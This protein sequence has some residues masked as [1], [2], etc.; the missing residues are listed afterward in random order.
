MNTPPPLPVPEP[1]E[2][3]PAETE[4]AWLA[5]RAYRDMPPEER[6]IR[7]TAAKAIST[8]SRWY[9]DHNWDER[10]KAHDAVMDKISVEERKKIYERSAREIAIDHMEILADLRD[11]AK[12][13][14][15]LFADSMRQQSMPGSIKPRDLVRFVEVGIK[16]D[17]L[18]RGETTENVGT[19]DLDVSKLSLQEVKDLE[20]LMRKAG[21]NVG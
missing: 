9:R 11:I 18:V 7:R 10:V 17:R 15:A 5:F 12:T 3:Q 21:M 4:E 20:K 13:E 16:M 14:L 2:R 8:L 19:T 6:Q 1:W